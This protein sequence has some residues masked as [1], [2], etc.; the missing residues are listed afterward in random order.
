MRLTVGSE[1]S[2]AVTITVVTTID[3]KAIAY[4]VEKAM[5]TAT[6]VESWSL[7]S[8]RRALAVRTKLTSMNRVITHESTC[9][10]DSGHSNPFKRA[11]AFFI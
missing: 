5:Q 1:G 6:K 7:F 8:I 3:V 2:L 9:K 10:K 4:K 11:A